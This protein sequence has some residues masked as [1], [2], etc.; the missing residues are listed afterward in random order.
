MSAG[1]WEVYS[2]R[3]IDLLPQ[4]L[5]PPPVGY[6]DE[7]VYREEGH[8]GRSRKR[9]VAPG[10]DGHHRQGRRNHPVRLLMDGG[11]SHARGQGR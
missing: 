3:R 11:A 4:P 10:Q 1:E 7:G 9:A 8:A 6:H 2:P 5:L